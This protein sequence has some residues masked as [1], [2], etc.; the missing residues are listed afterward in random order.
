MKL[1]LTLAAALVALSIPQAG[2][3][4]EPTDAPATPTVKKGDMIFG[5]D[6]KRI[7]RV[8]RVEEE[9]DGTRVI[10]VI[11]RSKM[12]S[13]PE[14]TLTAGERGFVASSPRSEFQ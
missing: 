2:I 9:K 12:L 8:Y 10:K 7:G 14:D 5:A 1:P 11:F 13:I 6:G 3:A 4:Q